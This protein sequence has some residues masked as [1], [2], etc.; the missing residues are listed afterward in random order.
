MVRKHR[1]EGTSLVVVLVLL[2][3]SATILLLLLSSGL[4]HRLQFRRDLQREQTRWLLRAGKEFL[5][6][7]NGLIKT[8]RSETE[9]SETESSETETPPKFSLSIP[10]FPSGT[11]TYTPQTSPGNTHEHFMIVKAQIGDPD[12]PTT[13]TTLTVRTEIKNSSPNINENR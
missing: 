13:L 10:H 1:S 11:I 4:R 6:T 3:I 9:P 12:D 5:Q 8:E 2:V 7:Q